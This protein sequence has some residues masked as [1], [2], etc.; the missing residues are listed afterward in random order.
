MSC[1][2]LGPRK[3]GKTHLLMSIQSPGTITSVSTSVPTIGTNIFTIK[4]PAPTTTTKSTTTVASTSTSTATCN[5]QK[6]AAV[7]AAASAKGIRPKNAEVD[8]LEIG[9]SMAPMWT[10]YLENVSRIIYVVDTSNLC[11]I[12]AAGKNIFLV[13]CNW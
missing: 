5:K 6:K 9:G 1:L 12:S 8:V 7:A 11:Q 3:S 2:C 10:S 13:I 4:L